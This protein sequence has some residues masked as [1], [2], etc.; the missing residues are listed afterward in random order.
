M[1]ID[2]KEKRSKDWAQGHPIIGDHGDEKEV[3]EETKLGQP[4]I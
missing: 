2:T 4:K 3:A 1:S